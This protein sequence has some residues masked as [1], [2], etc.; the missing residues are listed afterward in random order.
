MAAVV[1]LRA[2]APKRFLA[3]LSMDCLEHETDVA[4][5]GR[6]HVAEDIGC[7]LQQ[8]AAGIGNDQHAHEAVIDQ[9]A[10]EGRP[11]GIVLLSVR[12]ETS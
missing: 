7:T 2:P 5:L 10:Q 4:N 1:N 8:T 11:A 9:V 12:P 6:R 3:F